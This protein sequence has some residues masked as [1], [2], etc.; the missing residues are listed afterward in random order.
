MPLGV[1]SRSPPKRRSQLLLPRL[2]SSRDPAEDQHRYLRQ[3]G[4]SEAGQYRT[5]LR[6][7]QKSHPAIVA[8]SGLD[9]P[10]GGFSDFRLMA[11][12][13]GK[14][15]GP[16]PRTPA[17]CSS[18]EHD[19][20]ERYLRRTALRTGNGIVVSE[21]GTGRSC[22]LCGNW[23]FLGEGTLEPLRGRCRNS[24]PTDHRPAGWGGSWAAR[25]P[26]DG[27]I[28]WRVF[29]TGNVMRIGL[30]GDGCGGRARRRCGAR[31][32]SGAWKRR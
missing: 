26:M 22:R 17:A 7:I 18:P 14:I 6:L 1:C 27:A 32:V 12:F 2:V 3:D 19:T 30:P 21:P 24:Y 20:G 10:P 9:H 31:G 5:H 16:A 4:R 15:F 23:R 29:P 13:T 8:V 25:R 28:D 11:F